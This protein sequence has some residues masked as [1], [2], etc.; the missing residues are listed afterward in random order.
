[1]SWLGGVLFAWG[2]VLTLN[3]GGLDVGPPVLLCTS[4]SVND[5]V[6]VIKVWLTYLTFINSNVAA[7]LE[8]FLISSSW[9]L[10]TFAE[11]PSDHRLYQAYLSGSHST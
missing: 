8:S 7:L 11:A 4:T 10:V 5:G 1:V 2:R 6:R 9:T 3:F